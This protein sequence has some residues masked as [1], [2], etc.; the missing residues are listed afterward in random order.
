MALIKIPHIDVRQHFENIRHYLPS[1]HH[2]G[3]DRVGV[4]L[5]KGSHTELVR[6]LLVRRREAYPVAVQVSVHP[7]MLPYKAL[8]GC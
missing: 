6:E 4:V 7:E 5:A 2:V 1:E 3:D 8:T